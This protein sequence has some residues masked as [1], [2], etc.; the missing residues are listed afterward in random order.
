M[1]LLREFDTAL[2]LF[3]LNIDY[4]TTNI[5]ESSYFAL[6]QLIDQH[7]TGK[8]QKKQ[9]KKKQKQKKTNKHLLKEKE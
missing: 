8:K 7:I 9:N 3:I 1:L 4:I 2:C 5:L 6:D